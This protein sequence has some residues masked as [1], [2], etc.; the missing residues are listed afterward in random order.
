MMHS[1]PSNCFDRKC[2]PFSV[3]RH[4]GETTAVATVAKQTA[5]SPSIQRCESKGSK[6]QEKLAFASYII[7]GI[8]TEGNIN[9]HVAFSSA[10]RGPWQ[11]YFSKC[12]TNLM[13]S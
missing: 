5:P 4:I 1:N 11:V 3:Q 12:V 9:L 13:R 10:S 2:T 6:L 7:E 8:I